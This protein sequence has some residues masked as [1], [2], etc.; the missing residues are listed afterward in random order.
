MF[1]IWFVQ[2]LLAIPIVTMNNIQ[3]EIDDLYREYGKH[4]WEST[5]PNQK[6]ELINDFINRRLATLEAKRIGFENRPDI[7]KKLYDR[8][9]LT[10]VNITY[11]E[12]VAKPLISNE[13]LKKTRKYIDE[14]RL[15]NHILI[16]YQSAKIQNPPN[17]NQDEAL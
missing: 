3:Y 12:L 9:Q 17:R 14:E 6:E 5:T 4:E 1:Y 2:Y 7:A 11:E 16:S 13:L 15:L 8:T 10:L